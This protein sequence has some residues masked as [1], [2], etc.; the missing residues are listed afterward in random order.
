MAYQSFDGEKSDSDSGRKLE[1][2]KL[3]ADM[4]GK[5]LLD[6]G[7]NEGYFCFQAK[8][9]GASRVLGVDM[10]PQLI[11][12]ARKRTPDAE[13]ANL[14]WWD[15]DNEK[16]DYVLFL[17]AIHY[18]KDQR[19]LLNKLVNNLTPGG[20]LILEC[21]VIPKHGEKRWHVIERGDGVFKYPTFSLL[22]E[23]ILGS[24]AVRDMGPSVPQSGDPVPRLVF[25]CRKFVP[26][27]VLVSGASGAG[28]TIFTREISKLSGRV[29]NL[30][31][32]YSDLVREAHA[33]KSKALKYLK[34]N[35][36]S[37]QINVFLQ[38]ASEDKMI[39]GLNSLVALAV[40]PDAHLT[41]VEGYQFTLPGYTESLKAKLE[42]SGYRVQ[43]LSM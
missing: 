31:F 38:K 21:G 27:V 4:T 17:S 5:S 2:I 42:N 34:E 1:T 9:R 40:A 26:T 20:V 18:E 41:F 32:F 11:E 22:V 35:F 30:D 39:D 14:S 13:F 3:P 7:C 16:F 43:V 23:D 12:K 10:N 15:I 33:P 36:L 6:I 28:K 8:K 24:Y 37:G 29:I 25:H 19:A